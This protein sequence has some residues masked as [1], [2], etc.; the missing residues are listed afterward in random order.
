MKTTIDIPEALYKKV[1]IRAVE[2]GQTLRQVVLG[3]LAKELEEGVDPEMK[4][5]LSF[6]ERRRLVPAYKAAIE[7]GA[8]SGGNDS[9][10][11]VSEDRAS[12]EDALL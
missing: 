12:R 1:K 10:M 7:A 3:S 8:F 6:W 5:G 9:A 2:L 11:L 4:T